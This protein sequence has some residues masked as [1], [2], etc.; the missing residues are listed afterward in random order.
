M[1]TDRKFTKKCR[2][3]QLSKQ[4]NLFL[5]KKKTT[6]CKANPKFGGMEKQKKGYQVKK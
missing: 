1:E 5:L 6:T 4:I 2:T 3:E